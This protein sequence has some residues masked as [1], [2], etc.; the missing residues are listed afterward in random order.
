MDTLDKNSP[1]PM[2]Y[3]LKELLRGKIT[4][5]EWK[6]GDVI[7]SEREL[8]ERYRISRMTARQALVELTGEGIVRREQGKGTFVAEPKIMQSLSRLTGYTEDMQ[9]RALRP[10][11]RVLRIEMMGATER[12]AETLLIPTGAPILLLERLR[13]ADGT[14][15]A[16]EASHLHFDG[17]QELLSEDLENASLYQLLTEKWGV[18]PTKAEQQM[19]AALCSRRRQTLLDLGENAPVLKIRRTTYDQHGQPFEYV[20][21]TYRADRYV[22]H[23]EL[24]SL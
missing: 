2:Y 1:L 7:P 13:M 4:Q 22:F 18:I 11:A 23:V 8:S 19:E 14:P 3:Q 12:A 21:S 9:E 10:G 17:M 16:V 20:E 6:P 5:G 15:M 24:A